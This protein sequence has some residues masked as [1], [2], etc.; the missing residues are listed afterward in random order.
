[1][2]QRQSTP[3]IEK[4]LL[5]LVDPWIPREL[6]N[7]LITHPAGVGLVMIVAGAFMK[8]TQTPPKL[9][10]P[11]DMRGDLIPG[12]PQTIPGSTGLDMLLWTITLPVSV[13]D[14]ESFWNWVK[15]AVPAVAGVASGFSNP[16]AGL[17][18]QLVSAL[19]P[20][21]DTSSSMSN[22][23]FAIKVYLSDVLIITGA[24]IAGGSALNQVSNLIPKV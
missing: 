3:P 9:L 24:G 21:F 13:R 6:V 1:L 7:V 18:G 17:M 20:S 19:M 23:P 4:S 12:P 16:F 15:G 2:S 10:Y 22:A 14:A 5:D 11:R 8:Q